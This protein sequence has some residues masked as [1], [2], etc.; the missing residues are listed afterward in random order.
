LL[1]S[2]YGHCSEQTELGAH[3]A[4]FDDGKAHRHALESHACDER[5]SQCNVAAGQSFQDWVACG[6]FCVVELGS[7][8]DATRSVAVLANG[9]LA[10]GWRRRL[11]GTR[12]TALRSN[13]SPVF[14]W[15]PF[16]KRLPN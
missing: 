12:F 16:R 6:P 13:T 3:N 5:D 9:W 2:G 7:K 15:L 10:C 14:C 4:E 8:V 1:I 11:A